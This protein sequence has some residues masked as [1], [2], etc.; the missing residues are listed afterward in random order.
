MIQEFKHFN[1]YIW[2]KLAQ[3]NWHKTQLVEGYACKGSA[4]TVRFKTEEKYFELI[5]Y[6]FEVLYISYKSEST[7]VYTS[8]IEEKILYF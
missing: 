3:V 6:K 2:I 1:V 4:Q 8:K 5:N 7:Y